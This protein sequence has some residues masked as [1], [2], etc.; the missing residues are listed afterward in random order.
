MI[1]LITDSTKNASWTTLVALTLDGTAWGALLNLFWISTIAMLD[2]DFIPLLVESILDPVQF[3]LHA[4]EIVLGKV[5]VPAAFEFLNFVFT[6][7]TVQKVQEE[8][9]VTGK[10]TFKTF[11]RNAPKS[12]VLFF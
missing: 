3:C 10:Y 4:I 2:Q 12:F 11:R 8:N 7:A 5:V 9:K 1:Q 6:D